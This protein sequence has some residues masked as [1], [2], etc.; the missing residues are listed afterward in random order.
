MLYHT[1]ESDTGTTYYEANEEAAYFLLRSGKVLDIVQKRYGKDAKDVVQNLFLLGHAKVGDLVDAYK[2]KK[3]HAT[4]QVNGTQASGPA[5]PVNLDGILKRLLDDGIVEPLVTGM[6]RSPSDAYNEAERDILRSTN[7]AAGGSK[8]GKAAMELLRDVNRT[9]E[10][11]REQR[12]WKGGSMKRYHNGI[13][14]GSEKRRKL[15]NGSAATAGLDHF[16]DDVVLDR[17]L[18]VRVNYEKCTVALRSEALVSAAASEFGVIPAQVYGGLLCVLEDKITVCKSGNEDEADDDDAEPNSCTSTR[19]GSVLSSDINVFKGI[20]HVPE[21]WQK[22]KPGEIPSQSSSKR[23]RGYESPDASDDDIVVRNP[24]TNGVNGAGAESRQTRLTRIKDQLSLIS[25]D[26]QDLLKRLSN[27]GLGEFTVPFRQATAFMRQN[28]LDT[29]IAAAFG[30]EGLRLSHVLRKYGKLDEKQIQKLALMKQGEVRKTLVR[31]QMAGFAD[32]QEVPKDAMRT[33]NRMIFL[34]WF[35]TERIYKL[36]LD[37]ICKTMCRCF[38]VLETERYKARDVLASAS[39][40]DVANNEA[41]MLTMESM[42]QL[43]TFRDKEQRL[44]AQINRLDELV[45]IFRDF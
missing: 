32:I 11:H 25:I 29:Y 45:G 39:R 44:T 18:V 5:L 19:L 13:L 6:F 30:K 31:M 8:T 22:L 35:D 42:T 21:E 36:L 33:P 34:W 14:P 26:R 40:T 20:G 15:V 28:E 4:A 7:S 10:R 27:D 24:R 16:E 17:D 9:L 23:K 38:E 1:T 3:S 2:L 12:S 37:I 41:E 43:T